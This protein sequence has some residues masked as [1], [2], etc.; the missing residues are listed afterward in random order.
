MADVIEVSSETTV[1]ARADPLPLDIALT[2][3]SDIR[4][5]QLDNVLPKLGLE[6]TPEHRNWVMYATN[7]TPGSE[8][9]V[10]S[11]IHSNGSRELVISGDLTFRVVDI[12][13]SPRGT[14]MT[15]AYTHQGRYH[16][17]DEPALTAWAYDGSLM[18]KTYYYEGQKTNLDGPADISYYD[19]NNTVRVEEWFYDGIPRNITN[20]EP[21]VI[22]YHPDG[23][24]KT[25]I[26][27]TNGVQ[28]RREDYD[29]R[30]N[31]G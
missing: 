7:N 5:W 17:A 18:Y 13:Y 23:T 12:F 20:S 10:A 29:R 24:V 21:A 9:S 28:S 15:Q 30:G 22:V 4:S 16:N 1:T 26:W 8:V 3:W 19:G 27:Y 11:T 31:R 2:S 25:K 14:K 6:N